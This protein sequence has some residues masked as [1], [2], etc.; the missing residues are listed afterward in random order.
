MRRST[1][2]WRTVMLARPSWGTFRSAMSMP[3][4]TFSRETTEDCRFLGTV[5]ILRSRP[6]IRIRTR[7]S[8]SWGSRWIS[9]ARSTTARSMMELTSRTVGADCTSPSRMLTLLTGAASLSRASRFMSSMAR[10]AP[11]LP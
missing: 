8:P 2:P 10:A 3:P 9:L 4:M 5:R 11:S 1:S 6:S 7:T